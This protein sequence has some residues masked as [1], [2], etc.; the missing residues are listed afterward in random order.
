MFQLFVGEAVSRGIDPDEVG[1]FRLDELYLRHFFLEE[2]PR[3]VQISFEIG[4]DGL[5]PGAALPVRCFTGN[6]PHDI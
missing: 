4:L 2:A 1:S 6:E 3:E 5:E